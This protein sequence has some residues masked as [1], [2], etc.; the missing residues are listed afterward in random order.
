M[1]VTGIEGVCQGT[2]EPP[3]KD[4]FEAACAWSTR[5]DGLAVLVM[6]QGKIVHER[7]SGG[8]KAN[9][10]HHLFSGTKS[11]APIVALI[12]QSEGLLTLDE[13]VSR[14]ITEWADDPQKKKI[15]IRH[16]LSFTSGIDQKRAFA[17]ADFYKQAIDAP[18]LSDAGKR[19]RYGSNHLRV[20]GELL[21]RKLAAR[22]Q[23]EARGTKK[24][25]GAK[26]ARPPVD[27]VDYLQD[28]VLAPIGM[29]YGFWIRDRKNNPALSYGAFVTARDWARF[30]QLI[31]Q[32]GKWGDEQVVPDENLSECF[33]GSKANRQYGLN[34][35][36][37]GPG[38]HRRNPAIPADTVAAKGM[39]HQLLYVIPSAD[40]VIV[41]FG[42]VRSRARFSDLTFL[43]TLL[44][45]PRK[46]EPEPVRRVKVL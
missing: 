37:V 15:T 19:F 43:G 36:L 18:M 9:T 40:L 41:R 8:H 13:P 17:A 23:G 31:L 35:W 39:Y 14:T 44:A 38:L 42:K 6:H 1:A 45:R 29:K 25:K 16:L 11:F 20:F 7:Y 27:F 33:V 28:R 32:K 5:Q 10:A 34:W 26:K 4:A 2:G 22:T 24:G 12:A 21:E 30:G 46:S 3:T